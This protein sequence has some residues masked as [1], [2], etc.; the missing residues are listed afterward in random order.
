LVKI[1]FTEGPETYPIDFLDDFAVQNISFEEAEIIFII[2]N[3]YGLEVNFRIEDLKAI[4]TNKNDT[5]TL[6]SIMID[7]AL[8]VR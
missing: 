8:F 7:S 3:T 4:N 6:E 2:E 5:A 1:L